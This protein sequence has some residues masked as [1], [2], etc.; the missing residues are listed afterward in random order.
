MLFAL[1]NALLSSF[2][3]DGTTLVECQLIPGYDDAPVCL[4][5]DG[6]MSQ[7]C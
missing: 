5:I 7:K 4:Y 3:D 2:S 1:F 6:A